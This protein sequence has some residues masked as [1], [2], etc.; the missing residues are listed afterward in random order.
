M[1]SSMCFLAAI[2]RVIH[3]QTAAVVYLRTACEI[4]VHIYRQIFVE[5]DS[6]M[7]VCCYNSVVYAENVVGVQC[8]KIL[9][10]V[11]LSL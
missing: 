2:V 9:F 11:P 10:R 6:M 8:F 5:L 1:K 7:S 3:L 4:Y